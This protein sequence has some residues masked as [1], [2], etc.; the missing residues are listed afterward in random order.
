M[1]RVDGCRVIRMLD[2]S[3]ERRDIRRDPLEEKDSRMK[4]W[5]RVMRSLENSRT[6]QPFGIY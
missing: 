6:H 4:I 3:R 1:D 2:H 5:T